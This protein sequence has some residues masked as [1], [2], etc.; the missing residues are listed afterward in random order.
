MSH[1]FGS[2]AA[3]LGWPPVR[4]PQ[5]LLTM[6]AFVGLAGFEPATSPLSEVCSNQ[7]SYSPQAPAFR[8]ASSAGRDPT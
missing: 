7:L 2:T 1:G 4:L 8:S 3:M 5:E 6:E